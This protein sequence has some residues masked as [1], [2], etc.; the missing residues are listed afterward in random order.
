MSD[1]DR[2]TKNSQDIKALTR[3][4]R[5]DLVLA[6]CALLVSSVAAAASWAQIRLIRQNF[7]AQ[8]W[9]YVSMQGTVNG[10]TVQFA[11]VNAGLGPAILHSAQLSVDKRSVDFIGM[12]HAIL[13][14][15]IV[16]RA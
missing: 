7:S 1:G 9:P 14:P 16:A 5:F 8:V 6:I 10:D 2:E 15:N 12:M 11:I 3:G 13:G 4:V